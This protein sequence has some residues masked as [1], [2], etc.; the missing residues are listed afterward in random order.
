MSQSLTI[1]PSGLALGNDCSIQNLTPDN[2]WA[3]GTELWV[4]FTGGGKYR[5]LIDF[6]LT[7]VREGKAG[8]PFGATI[9]TA[10]LSLYV[11]TAAGSAASSRIALVRADALVDDALATWNRWDGVRAWITAGGDYDAATQ[12]TWTMPTSGSALSITGLASLVQ[13][14]LDRRSGRCCFLLKQNDET[15]ANVLKVGR[16]GAAYNATPRAPAL[17]LTYTPIS[18]DTNEPSDPPT[19][20]DE[21]Q[22]IATTTGW[23]DGIGDA[24]VFRSAAP[25]SP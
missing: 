1:R 4:G 20:Y 15:A 3:S 21:I 25:A 13:T 11:A 23:G 14:A 22:D 5:T 2:A 10:S 17:I 8:I 19:D 18:A 12:V 9:L 24:R 16:S 6:D 7:G